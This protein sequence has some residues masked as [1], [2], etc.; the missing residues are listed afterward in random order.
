MK[1]KFNIAVKANNTVEELLAL[2]DE[3]LA[4]LIT[5]NM[6]YLFLFLVILVIILT[7]TYCCGTYLA[8]WLHRSCHFRRCRFCFGVE[9]SEEQDQLQQKEKDINKLLPNNDNEKAYDL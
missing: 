6:G 1:M 4:H 9:C 7:S 2:T 5:E 8:I 3:L